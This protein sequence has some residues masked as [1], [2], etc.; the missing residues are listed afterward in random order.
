MTQLRE[1][2]DFADGPLVFP[3]KGKRYEAP[4]ITITMGIRL[5]A[6]TNDGAE[7]D[8]NIK[9]LLPDLL[10]PAWDEMIAD[11]VPLAVATRAGVSILADFQYGREYAALM[12][13]TGGDPHEMAERIKAKGNRATRRAKPRTASTAPPA[14]GTP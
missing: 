5:N 9:D 2:T 11:G 10:G 6:I 8:L 12:W 4:E 1:F 14:K 3:Y 13:E 7:A